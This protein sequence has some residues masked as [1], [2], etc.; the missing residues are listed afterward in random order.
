MG[1]W[2]WGITSGCREPA[3]AW[4]FLSYL[5]STKEI[6]RMTKV[7]GAIPARRS[8]LMQSPLHNRRGPIRVFVQQL[9]AGL[10]V[11]RP[12]T[13]A[14]STISATFSQ[15][16]NNILAG[17]DVQTELSKA[18]EIIDQDIAAHRGY[19]VY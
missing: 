13:P 4:A 6:L 9:S 8:A 11:P 18:A 17:G 5:M 14:Y 16:I 3:G 19:P 12:V 2:S 10:G 1:S 15:A 7:N